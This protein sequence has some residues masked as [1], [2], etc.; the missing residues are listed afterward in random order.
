MEREV[1]M[2]DYVILEQGATSVDGLIT[3]F[4]M[5]KGKIQYVFIE[6]IKSGFK[7]NE[8][9]VKVVEDEI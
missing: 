5:D 9:E 6:H 4:L 2:G 7:V 3:G 1:G 8:W